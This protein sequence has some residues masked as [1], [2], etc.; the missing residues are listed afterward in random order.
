MLTATLKELGTKPR[1]NGMTVSVVFLVPSFVRVFNKN[2]F[3]IIII[4][5]Y[6]S[7][8]IHGSISAQSVSIAQEVFPPCKLK[9]NSS[10][11]GHHLRSNFHVV[12][13]RT[14]V[15]VIQGVSFS[16]SR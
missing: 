15:T 10:L 13:F 5:F 6:Y 3:P 7:G 11:V 2:P 9:K 14:C 8:E 1:S 12:H 16:L 4:I